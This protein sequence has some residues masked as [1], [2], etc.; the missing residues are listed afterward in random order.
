VKS[1]KQAL[2]EA[3]SIPQ[4]IIAMDHA[5]ST[6]KKKEVEFGYDAIWSIGKQ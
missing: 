6:T 2:V 4:L 1:N 5:L 3:C